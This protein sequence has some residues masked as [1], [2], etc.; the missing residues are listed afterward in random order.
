MESVTARGGWVRGAGC[1]KPPV[2]LGLD[3]CRVV[4]QSEHAAP[5]ELV[6]L[7]QAHG[8]VIADA[9][10]GATVPVGARAAVVLAQDPVLAARR[11]AV[12]R[13]AALSADEDPL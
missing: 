11:A 10:F 7:G 2:D 1:L 12:V 6:D 13:V 3:E 8:P 4:E 9:A 5:D